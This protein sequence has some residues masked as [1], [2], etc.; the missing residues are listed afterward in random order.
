MNIVILIIDAISYNYSWL[1]SKDHFPY[2]NTNSKN[3]LNF[4]NHYGVSNGTR[5]NLATILSGL[6]PSLH[7]TMNRKNSFRN[8]KYYNIQKILGTK[9]YY[10]LYFGTQPLFHSEKKGDNLDFSDAIYLSPSMADYY[11][12][13]LKFN[14]FVIN[15][16]E[17]I[18]NKNHFCI[19]HYT[20]V[21]APFEPPRVKFKN[22]KKINYFL[23]KNFHHIIKRFF[24]LKIQRIF[25]KK[26]REVL[27]N[28]PHLVEN[29]F[30][31][32]QNISL[33]RFPL[34]KKFYH[35]VWNTKK[36]YEDYIQMHKNASNYQDKSIKEIL[37]Y[38]KKNSK[39]TL[40][41]MLADHGNSDLIDPEKRKKE[42][43][44]LKDLV[45]VPLS[46][47]SFDEEINRRLKLHGDIYDLTSHADIFNTILNLLTDINLKKETNSSNYIQD[48]LNI[49]N[50]NRYIFSEFNDLRSGKGRS[51]KGE[52]KMFNLNEEYLF[53]MS[54]SDEI[55]DILEKKN[56]LNNFNK[57]DY[58]KY[59][60][61]K[62][63]F[64]NK[65]KEIKKFLSNNK[66][67]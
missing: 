2:L 14:N 56:I 57:Q 17:K 29:S 42:G 41:L 33:E 35:E 64:N 37:E 12:P 58:E 31:L 43:I 59:F 5:N 26:V 46:I 9:G 8:N 44:L 4:H 66:I 60:T 28:Y 30:P 67:I 36:L 63:E 15:H 55:S 25:S 61:Y 62:S 65:I 34:N 21:H 54:S 13:G 38:F 45:H 49:E 22:T 1:K 19:Y 23:A 11:I 7:K 48:L 10:T 50:I 18:K 40:F 16:H 24:W 20:D 53:N 3:F 51:D 27:N 47:F 6:P 52:I 39:N 32:G